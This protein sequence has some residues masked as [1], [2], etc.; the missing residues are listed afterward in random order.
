MERKLHRFKGIKYILSVAFYFTCALILLELISL[1]G[2]G[3]KGLSSFTRNVSEHT[4]P[5]IS[6]G[7]NII[8]FPM[9][10][11]R[12]RIIEFQI[13]VLLSNTIRNASGPCSHATLSSRLCMTYT[14]QF[15]NRIGPNPTFHRKHLPP[16]IFNLLT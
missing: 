4:R 2:L 14:Q 10:L 1:G 9:L 15:S 3:A 8:S 6:L 5:L 11:E 16:Y 13:C 7:E 12:E